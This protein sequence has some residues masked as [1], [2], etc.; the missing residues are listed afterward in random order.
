M[1]SN[2]IKWL[3]V[4]NSPSF[5]GAKS[6]CRYNVQCNGKKL[7]H[8]NKPSNLVSISMDYTVLTGRDISASTVHVV[9]TK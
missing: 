6:I 3:D 7:F 1:N 5:L 2:K 4:Q 8:S 9:L